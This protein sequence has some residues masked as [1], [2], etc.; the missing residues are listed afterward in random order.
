V[1][2]RGVG[3]LLYRAVEERALALR[4]TEIWCDMKTNH[5]VATAFH[6]KVHL[7]LTF[8]LPH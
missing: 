8:P 2:Q 4:V 7:L 1:F 6:A 5:E 3:R